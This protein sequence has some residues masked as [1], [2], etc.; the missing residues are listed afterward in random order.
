MT[1]G[2]SLYEI[3]YGGIYAFFLGAF[4]GFA[5]DFVRLIRVLLGT[6]YQGRFIK[7]PFSRRSVHIEARVKLFKEKHRIYRTLI[8]VLDIVLDFIYCLFCGISVAIF[9]Y[10]V[11]C[12]VFR[13]LFLVGAFFGFWFYR[14]TIG[15]VFFFLLR[16]IAA[17]FY[18]L[19]KMIVYTVCFLMIRPIKWIFLHVFLPFYRKLLLLFRKKYVIINKKEDS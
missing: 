3:L 4:L 11:N 15:R 9:L 1:L 8:K 14:K 10:A 6:V 18:L 19:T 16:E 7:G 12:G 13:F 5:Y 17:I 2:F